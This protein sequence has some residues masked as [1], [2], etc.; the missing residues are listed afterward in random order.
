[1]KNLVRKQ[2]IFQVVKNLNCG[3]TDCHLW[4]R[5]GKR[6]LYGRGERFEIVIVYWVLACRAPRWEG[7]AG[8]G[9]AR[10][11]GDDV[12]THS[13]AV[14]LT[15]NRKGGSKAL[16]LRCHLNLSFFSEQAKWR[17]RWTDDG[18]SGL[19]GVGWGPQ[20]FAF[21]KDCQVCEMSLICSRLSAL[22]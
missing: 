12:N 2:S 4:R 18:A 1:M 6:N 7:E 11:P 15:A 10:A 13:S 20:G 5:E 14:A 17:V 9:D 3:Y 19:R 16:D 21:Y 22:I 8:R